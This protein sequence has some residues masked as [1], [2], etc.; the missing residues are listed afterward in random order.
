MPTLFEY[1]GIRISFFSNEHMPIHIHAF[2]NG[3]EVVVKFFVKDETIYKTTYQNKRGE[4]SAKEMKDLKD[5]VGRYK[6]NIIIL[7]KQFFEQGVTDIQPI[8]LTKK[9]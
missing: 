4:F 8:V 6:Y 9:I 5:F 7:W 1:M 3:N 2:K